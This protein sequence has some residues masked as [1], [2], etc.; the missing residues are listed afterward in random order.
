MEPIRIKF[1]G[2]QKKKVTLL[3]MVRSCLETRGYLVLLQENCELQ[4][5]EK[6]R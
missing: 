2:E 5:C 1:E 3:R 6:R 4:V